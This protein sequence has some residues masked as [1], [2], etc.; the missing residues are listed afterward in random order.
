[1]EGVRT[2]MMRLTPKVRTRAQRGLV[3]ICAAVLLLAL[4]RCRQAPPASPSDGL[5]WMLGDR[6][7]TPAPSSNGSCNLDLVGDK[8]DT[9][10]VVLGLL[11]EYLGRGF[12]ED[13]D[14]VERFYC[15]EHDKAALFRRLIVRLAQEQGLDPTIRD[16]TIQGCLIAYH[17]KAI[18]DRL[19]S[20]YSYQMTSGTIAPGAD[21]TYRRTATA[22]L[23]DS[24]FLRSGLGAGRGNGLADEAFHRRRALAYLAG[25]WNRYG[26]GAD[27]GFANSHDKAA[28][29]AEL[30][31]HLGCQG[32]RLETITGGAP[33]AN[34]VHF[35]PTAEVKTWLEKTW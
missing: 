30:L 26:R 17:S 34:I 22:S 24:L 32:V 6:A 20:C 16:E 15:D 1:M 19:N 5:D 13:D 12:L 29:I 28:L 3:A 33:N 21:G 2:V 9:V 8:G 7:L 14:R 35:E 18:A 4:V 23:G 11:D 25:A 27:F 10:F 31:S